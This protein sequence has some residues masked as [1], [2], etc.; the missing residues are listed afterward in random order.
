MAYGA[1]QAILST[2]CLQSYRLYADHMHRLQ[3]AVYNPLG[4]RDV[5]VAFDTPRRS[6]ATGR[7]DRSHKVSEGDGDIF[8]TESATASGP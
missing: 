6:V 8:L 7:V 3:L 1:R 5:T 2:A 4:N